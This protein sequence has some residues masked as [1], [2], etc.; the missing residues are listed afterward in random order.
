MDENFVITNWVGVGDFWVIDLVLVVDRGG[1]F[2]QPLVLGFVLL[3]VLYTEV[4]IV[5]LERG[6]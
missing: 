1:L 5:I 4:L 6:D 3:T 2:C